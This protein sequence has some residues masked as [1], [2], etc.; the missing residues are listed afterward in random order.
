ME[1]KDETYFE[2]IDFYASYSEV[3]RDANGY[4]EISKNKDKIEKDET[5]KVTLL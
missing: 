5:V 4:I 1:E 2:A 3:M